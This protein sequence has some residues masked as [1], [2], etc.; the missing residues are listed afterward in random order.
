MAVSVAEKQ[1]WLIGHGKNKSYS[2]FMTGG[3]MGP[4]WDWNKA[5]AGSYAP[6]EVDSFL[7]DGETA[8]NAGK[9]KAK[10]KKVAGG[11][12]PSSGPSTSCAKTAAKTIT[13]WVDVAKQNAAGWYASVGKQAWKGQTGSIGSSASFI[14][15]IDQ[16]IKKAVAELGDINA[17]EVVALRNLKTLMQKADSARAAV[18][19]NFKA[20]NA[21]D[22]EDYAKVASHLDKISAHKA[23]VELDNL[24]TEAIAE[25]L[26]D[27][28]GNP[29]FAVEKMVSNLKTEVQTSQ[30]SVVG[31]VLIRNPNIT[32][33]LKGLPD[34]LQGYYSSQAYGEVADWIAGK[35]SPSSA[36]AIPTEALD[37][38]DDLA[39]FAKRWVQTFTDSDDLLSAEAALDLAGDL[40]SGTREAVGDNYN[41]VVDAFK[42]WGEEGYWVEGVHTGTLEGSPIEVLAADFGE[43]SVAALIGA[44]EQT[45]ESILK[46]GANG[47][48]K[49]ES[50]AEELVVYIG[51]EATTG[52][53]TYVKVL[54]DVKSQLP[55]FTATKDEVLAVLNQGYVKGI[56]EAGT[57]ELNGLLQIKLVDQGES[58][59]MVYYMTK[60]QK[61]D[62]ILL[63]KE[64][65]DT[66]EY[67]IKY[68]GS[69]LTGK[70][71]DV[72]KKKLLVAKGQKTLTEVADGTVDAGLPVT[73][74]AFKKPL[75][76]TQV[77]AQPTE[78]T[79]DVVTGATDTHTI[80]KDAPK[81]WADPATDKQKAYAASLVQD[82]DSGASWILHVIPKQ[83]DGTLTKGQ[84]SLVIDVLQ[85]AKDKGTSATFDQMKDAVAYGKK[86][87]IHA[88]DD[89]VKAA[90]ANATEVTEDVVQAA[91]KAVEN[92][93]AVAGTV[94]KTS[95]AAPKN[96]VWDEPHTFTYVGDGKHKWGG[97]H[98]K[99]HFTDE[100]GT[101]WML[102]KADGFR[103]DGELAAHKV[104]HLAG[105]D[106]AE[107][108]ITTQKVGGR[109]QRGFMQ[110]MY[111]KE[112]IRG[113]L[114]DVAGNTFVG[115]D[116]DITRQIQEQQ[117]YDW[118]IGNHD[119]HSG[120]FLVMRDGRVVSIDKGQAFK[121]FGKDELS[122]TYNP[123]GAY[124]EK[125]AYN[126][127]WE[128]YQ[129]GKIALDLDS[130]D[131]ALRRI[132]SISDDQYEKAIR[133]YAEGRFAAVSKGADPFL[134]GTTARSADEFVELALERK[135]NIRADFTKFYKERS[136]ARGIDWTPSWA[137]DVVPKKAAAQV[138]EKAAVKPGDIITPINQEFADGLQ[139]A[140]TAGKA[141]FTG[142]D[143]IDKG[144]Q[145]LF[146]IVTDSQ[147][148]QVLRVNLNL[149]P[150]ADSRLLKMMVEEHG[151]K[152]GKAPT[153][154][155]NSN[156]PQTVQTASKYNSNAT[157]G[158]K[159]INFHIKE[160]DF[161]PNVTTINNV[162]SDL[163]DAQSEIKAFTNAG[164]KADEIADSKLD[165]FIA[166]LVGKT[167]E[168]TDQA[169]VQFVTTEAGNSTN[170]KAAEHF[171]PHFEEVIKQADAGAAAQKVPFVTEFD[172]AKH[173][174][175]VKDSALK[176]ARA[177]IAS[178]KLEQHVEVAPPAKVFKS[179]VRESTHRT[180]M[181][182]MQQG[183]S[184]EYDQFSKLVADEAQSIGAGNAVGYSGFTDDGVE[185]IYR[186][187]DGSDFTL[188]GWM[189]LTIRTDDKVELA[190]IEKAY[191]FITE[192]LGV[193]APL[194]NTVDSELTYWRQVQGMYRFSKEGSSTTSKY[195]KALD[196]ADQQVRALGPNPTA[197]SEI[198]AIRSAWRQQFG[199]VI[200]EAD[201][202]PIYKHKFAGHA[203]EYGFGGWEKPEIGAA[204]LENLKGT[205][206]AHDTKYG[207]GVVD[208]RFF[209][210]PLSDGMWS[211]GERQRLGM[212]GVSSQTGSDIGTG[213]ATG[214][215]GQ[216][217]QENYRSFKTRRN[218][219]VYNP[220]KTHKRLG[221][222]NA[223]GDTYGRVADRTSRHDLSPAKFG[224]HVGS[225]NEVM[226]RDAVSTMD[227]LEIAFF[228]SPR[229]AQEAIASAK[230][231]GVTHIRGVPVEERFVYRESDANEYT[232]QFF[233]KYVHA[234]KGMAARLRTT[235][236][237]VLNT[238]GRA[239]SKGATKSLKVVSRLKLKGH[240]LAKNI[241]AG[242][243]SYAQIRTADGYRRMGMRWHA[244]EN[245][246]SISVK[247][248]EDAF[249]VNDVL[250]TTTEEFMDGIGIKAWARGRG[251]TVFKIGRYK[252]E[253]ESVVIDLSEF[254]IDLKGMSQYERP[255]VLREMVEA[256]NTNTMVEFAAK[257]GTGITP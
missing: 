18:D 28:F 240:E 126:T 127:M 50:T 144:G 151:D 119:G 125:V 158:A 115:L 67:S 84:M 253:A 180:T 55:G 232:R 129:T 225:W 10:A 164:T 100:D 45:S 159:S 77:A 148:K 109:S 104:G 245:A 68:K 116:D 224:N 60:A 193:K 219:L 242:R 34:D 83:A 120:N 52:V 33:G 169:L 209:K 247:S 155:I 212:G 172:A 2:Y 47:I 217:Q 57:D 130:I 75:T 244:N 143:E 198:N 181:V 135:R 13:N 96:V 122:A 88:G 236:A 43:D 194:G 123:N 163:L 121:F 140:G 29:K 39:L 243:T 174:G 171:K 201:T 196:L 20:F 81:W 78:A 176:R 89:V 249:G 250:A 165:E 106:I 204:N 161:T 150:E 207:D 110:K 111:R 152:L 234:G 27:L 146:D 58:K 70:G 192:R 63:P 24:D 153:V 145:I 5:V 71:L 37:N 223:A 31:Q 226:M 48:W 182:D 167:P 107:A 175:E 205:I 133:N 54:E 113:E 156:L 138:L 44:Q 41:E 216:I 86:N 252:Q 53:T 203:E 108:R 14:K 160:G 90:V 65:F 99:W 95:T 118:L 139:R 162:K 147:G 97:A 74:V 248:L 235:A 215:F 30:R 87:L 170:L 124:G 93:G 69:K 154:G 190:D 157:A 40:A 128:E 94:Q 59:S 132:E 179:V 246:V 213:G 137:D 184:G 142:T 221:T 189:E 256:M 11:P 15:E 202:L 17:D 239:V 241:S 92:G 91:V 168:E 32:V 56:M 255:Q 230:L 197:E 136:A 228:D 12:A 211:Q 26:D 238:A 199:T 173:F 191:A 4:D 64:T 185:M 85:D 227:D 251:K 42:R 188:Q 82:T 220:A 195:R 210:G 218:Y 257:W 166:T 36:G 114:R 101:D 222:Y 61:Q 73:D 102:K 231:R 7:S 76:P 9:A 49:A 8:Y 66:V 229:G 22:E 21:I 177:K 80:P 62:Y 206:V 25:L 16:Q 19:E 46:L 79:V 141:I 178:E 23:K 51:E 1:A 35:L 149:R 183:W 131:D 98:S 186:Q 208:E 214:F 112:E 233:A 105:Y 187:I 103:A 6:Y 254:G 117:V 134:Q 3:T 200:D 38:L 72:S 237:E